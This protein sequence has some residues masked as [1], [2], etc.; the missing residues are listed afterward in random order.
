MVLLLQNSILQLT[1]G[2]HVVNMFGAACSCFVELNFVTAALSETVTLTYGSAEMLQS[3]QHDGMGDS[4]PI[5]QSV[6]LSLSK[7]LRMVVRE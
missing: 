3:L 6:T 5:P 7:G 2:K 4:E 1:K